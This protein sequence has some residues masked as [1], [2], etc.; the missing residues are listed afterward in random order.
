[1]PKNY[2]LMFIIRCNE[3]FLTKLTEIATTK[4]TKKSKII[5]DLVAKE[6]E[7]MKEYA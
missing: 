4:K 5:R 1:M 2:P 7:K 6:Y 3:E